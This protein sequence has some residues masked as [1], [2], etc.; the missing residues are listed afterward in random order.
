MI[1]PYKNLSQTALHRLIEEFVT[2][3]GTDTG[4]TDGSLEESVES[5]M[6]QLNSGDAVIVY[7]ETTHIVPKGSS[8]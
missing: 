2:R 3:G 8:L 1:I 7:D 5:V 6:Q 4:Y